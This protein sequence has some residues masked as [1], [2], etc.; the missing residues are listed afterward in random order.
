[1]CK[2]IRSPPLS[3]SVPDNQ[4]DVH[5]V[6]EDVSPAWQE[7]LPMQ[8]DNA[9]GSSSDA[10]ST[11]GQY[12]RSHKVWISFQASLTTNTLTR[13]NLTS[14]D[15]YLPGRSDDYVNRGLLA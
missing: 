2:R 9:T 5:E 13:H 8:G 6:M 11:A 1:M 15:L 14:K 12:R 3:D 4:G 10:K 7:Y